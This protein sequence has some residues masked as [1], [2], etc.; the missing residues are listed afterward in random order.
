VVSL[1][2]R[3]R[4]SAGRSMDDRF[5]FSDVSGAW[6]LCF[7]PV[8]TDMRLGFFDSEVGGSAVSTRFRFRR[9]PTFPTT[10]R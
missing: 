10:T 2:L 4:F 1:M 7:S 3:L 5:D 8:A 6:R 9:V